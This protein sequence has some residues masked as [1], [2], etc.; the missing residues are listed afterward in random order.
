MNRFNDPLTGGTMDTAFTLNDSVEEGLK[1]LLIFLL[2]A[3]KIQAA[4][5]LNRTQGGGAAAY[6]LI[7]DPEMMAQACPLVPL[8][9]SNAAS[10][11]SRLT[12]REPLAGPIA[13]VVRPCELRAFIELVKRG[14]GSLDNFIFIS[15]VCGGVYPLQEA[16]AEGGIE[17]KIP[18]YWQALRKG[19]IAADIRSSCRACEEFI[20]LSADM[21][22]AV[23]GRDDLESRCTVFLQT[24]RAAELIQGLD[25]TALAGER[26]EQPLESDP[27]RKHLGL[28][29]DQKKKRSQEMKLDQSGL[30]GLIE[31]FGKCIGCHGCRAVCPIC[32][33]ELCVFESKDFEPKPIDFER[34]LNRK[35]KLRVPPDMLLYHLG[36]LNHMAVS[37]VGCGS[38]TDVCPVDI[39][40]SSIFSQ[41][42]ESLQELFGYLPGRDP[43]EEVPFTKYETEELAEFED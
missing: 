43:E 40:V 7:T 25:N 20:P 11:L 29:R 18:D 26:T 41:V 34:D 9:P 42:G 19:E 2:E 35:G 8:M 6:S 22:V 1:R 37:C 33:C 30:T 28:R 12:L 32:Y 39:P 13:A 4:M 21:T 31:I 15:S 17:K 24:D 5:V 10:A 27:V 16:L 36:R 23:V 3:G 38:C 14:Q